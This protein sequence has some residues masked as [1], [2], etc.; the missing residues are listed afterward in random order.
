M[1]FTFDPALDTDFDKVRF[2]SGD[3][4]SGTY[5]LDDATITALLASEGSVGAAVMAALDFALA[6]AARPDV[7]TVSTETG[8]IAIIGAD[9]V[10][11]LEA[12]RK[13]AA[14]RFGIAL[15]T[16]RTVNVYR[17]DSQQASEPDYTDG[18]DYSTSLNG[19]VDE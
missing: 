10:A 14:K 13:R 6:Y 16:T 9:V 1:A 5:R 12:L 4:I 19:S 2:W 15:I 3:T 8:G 11:S 18:T 17:A 7:Q